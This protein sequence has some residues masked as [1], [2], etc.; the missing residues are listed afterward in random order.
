MAHGADAGAP[1]FAPR[2]RTRPRR[3]K[4]D[5]VKAL[6]QRLIAR[7]AERD[8]RTEQESY[9]LLTSIMRDLGQFYGKRGPRARLEDGLRDDIL[10]RLVEAE[11]LLEQHL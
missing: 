11:R 8:G 1:R 2:P 6:I 3:R 7:G 4:G 5:P 9:R 10:A